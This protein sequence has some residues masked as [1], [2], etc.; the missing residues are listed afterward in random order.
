MCDG[1]VGRAV[2]GEDRLDLDA[3]AAVESDR[4]TEEGGSGRCFL[5]CEHLGISEAAVV[6]DGDVVVLPA[7]PAL[8]PPLVAAP[9][10]AT[11][12][13]NSVADTGDTPE[14]LH[15]DVHELTRPRALVTHGRLE[16]DPAEPAQPD[17]REDP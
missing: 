5:V 11:I 8:Q 6:V 10:A 16:S 14:L 1:D 3:V 7:R 13:G 4:A 2:V 17:P 15:I 12:A 9:L